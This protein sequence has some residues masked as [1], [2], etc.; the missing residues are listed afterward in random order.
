MVMGAAR[1]EE[2]LGSDFASIESEMS[3]RQGLYTSHSVRSIVAS[4]EA[5]RRGEHVIISNEVLPDALRITID[6]VDDSLHK[7]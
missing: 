7:A 3:E 4:G 1:A 6:E 5:I 2:D